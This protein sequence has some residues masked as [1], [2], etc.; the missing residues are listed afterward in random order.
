MKGK[1]SDGLQTLPSGE[2]PTPCAIL[3][4]PIAQVA[5]SPLI[6]NVPKNGSNAPPQPAQARLP[7][8]RRAGVSIFDS[9]DA[10]LAQIFHI[11]SAGSR[12]APSKRMSSGAF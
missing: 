4:S 8:E 11:R 2:I 5:E 3:R 9:G 7:I 6:R 1:R 10:A 12:A